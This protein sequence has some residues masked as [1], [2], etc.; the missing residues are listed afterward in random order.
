MGPVVPADCAAV[1]AKDT[2]TNGHSERVA[3]YASRLSTA[4]GDSPEMVDCVFRSGTLHDVGKI[5]VPDAILKKTGKLDPDEQ[6]VMQTHAVLGELI[7]GPH[8][9]I[10]PA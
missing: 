2:Y 8:S 9:A 4:L 10:V 5:G 6:L 1:D 3:R 7:V